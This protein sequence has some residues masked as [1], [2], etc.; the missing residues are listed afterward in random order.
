MRPRARVVATAIAILSCAGNCG[1]DETV[2]S[3]VPSGAGPISD[4]GGDGHIGLDAA[5]FPQNPIDVYA[6][7]LGSY[8]TCALMRGVAYCWGLNAYGQIGTGDGR[9]PRDVPTPV[10]GRRVFDMLRAGDSHACGLEHETGRVYCWGRGDWGQLG[11]GNTV[12][13]FEPKLVTLPSKARAIAAGHYH[14]CAILEGGE[15]YCW[16]HNLEGEIGIGTDNNDVL[17]PT[18]VGDGTDWTEIVGGQGHTCGLRR[19]PSGGST[20]WCWGRNSGGECGL[21]PP[22]PPTD[23]ILVP[24]QVGTLDDWKSIDLG[25]AIA[26]GIPTDGSLRCWGAGGDAVL[27]GTPNPIYQPMTIGTDRDWTTV[28]VDAFDTCGIITGNALRCWGRNWEGQLGVGEYSVNRTT[29]TLVPGTWIEVSVGRFHMC[30]MDPD[31]KISCT[32]E[33]SDGQVGVSVDAG[34][35][36]YNVLQPVGVPVPGVQ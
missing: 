18:R 6:L 11:Q 16:G 5:D 31:H 30:A 14:A 22:S 23:R 1:V 9:T 21:G 12:T 20:L 19:S 13:E 27:D 2:L 3:R 15:L 34:T 32:G 29:P 10:L 4:A 28:S 35:T 7:A 8:F 26:C 25:Q 36:R 17:S 33:N 24:T